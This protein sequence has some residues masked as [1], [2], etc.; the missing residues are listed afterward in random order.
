MTRFLAALLTSG[1]LLSGTAMAAATKSTPPPRSKPNSI[2]YNA[3]KS[4]TGNKLFTPAPMVTA[5]PRP[6]SA[7]AAP[8]PHPTRRPHH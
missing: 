8:K 2:N 1:V 3:S 6:R 7:G 4:N 5:S